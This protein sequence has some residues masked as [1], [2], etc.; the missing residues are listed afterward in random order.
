MQLMCQKLRNNCQE[1][2]EKL[3]VSLVDSAEQ[4]SHS[5]N[6]ST[7]LQFKATAAVMNSYIML[8]SS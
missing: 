1:V 2:Q 8:F 5:V 3:N 7:F 4:E 6:F